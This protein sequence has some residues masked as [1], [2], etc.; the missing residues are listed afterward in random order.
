MGK[1][2]KWIGYSGRERLNG[3]V[4]VEQWSADYMH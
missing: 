1:E 4:R 2:A 3:L